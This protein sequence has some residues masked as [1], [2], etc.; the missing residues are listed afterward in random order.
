MPLEAPNGGN[1]SDAVADMVELDDEDLADAVPINEWPT[2]NRQLRRF[3][4]DG[5]VVVVPRQTGVEKRVAG[6]KDMPPFVLER[7]GVVRVVEGSAADHFM[8]DQG[9]VRDID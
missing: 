2:G 1:G 5:K 3:M 6:D 7:G 8:V 4:L 9:G